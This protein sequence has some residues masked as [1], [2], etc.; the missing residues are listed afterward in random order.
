MFTVCYSL[1]M[2]FLDRVEAILLKDKDLDRVE[3]I[4]LLAF[5]ASLT[6]FAVLSILLTIGTFAY[7]LYL[8]NSKAP[9]IQFQPQINIEDFD[10]YYLIEDTQTTN[11]QQNKQTLNINRY[12]V[13]EL[14]YLKTIQNNMRASFKSNVNISRFITVSNINE[15]G[16]YIENER[17]DY[18]STYSFVQNKISR[19]ELFRSVSLQSRNIDKSYVLQRINNFEDKYSLLYSLL[20]YFTFETLNLHTE[21]M[22]RVQDQLVENYADREF[23]TLLRNYSWIIGIGLF[24]FFMM[25]LMIFKIESN[26]RNIHCVLSKDK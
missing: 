17:D 25:Y 3:A 21:H 11:Q 20:G 6:I 23:G 8:S 19:E 10:N 14:E 7:G 22:E 2:S 12:S 4:L 1:F 16:N 13:V 24:S 26:I 18:Y 9:N 5:R 15:I